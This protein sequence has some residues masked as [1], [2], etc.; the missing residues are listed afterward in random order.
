MPALSEDEER[1]L[2]ARAREGDANAMETLLASCRTALF[3]YIYRMVTHR[4]DAEDLFQETQLEAIESVATFRGSSRFK[5]WLFAIATHACLDHL[6]RKIRWRRDTQLNAEVACRADRFRMAQV[7]TL[8][9]NP[10]VRFEIREHIAFCFSCVARTLE[11]ESQAALMLKEVV[12]LSLEEAARVLDLSEPRFRHK[13]AASRR[14]MKESFEGMCQLVNKTG[15][16]WQCRGLRELAPP[17]NQG[18]DLV[19]IELRPGVAITPDSI[20]DARIAIARS[21]DLARGTS[22]AL[23]DD[24]FDAVTRDEEALAKSP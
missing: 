5:T 1:L 4:E 12:G 20:L 10:E 3:A 16:C 18:E 7:Q 23:H 22:A 21:A 8:L 14:Q 24:L 19:Q 11:P 6:R 9:A 13:L 2:V 15:A 17:E